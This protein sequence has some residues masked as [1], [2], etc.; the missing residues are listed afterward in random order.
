MKVRGD[1]ALAGNG[2]RLG[3]G[4]PDGLRVE[5]PLSSGRRRLPELVLGIFL[6]AGCALGAVLLAASGR[7][8]T[9]ALALSHDV[10]RGEVLSPED[11][12]T[13]Y[14]G[15]DSPI[16]FLRDGDDDQVL[17]RAALTDMK[18][19]TLV[20][21]GQFAPPTEVLGQ[22]DGAVGL[23]VEASE[24]PS[25]GL[26]PGD[27]VTVISQEPTSGAGAVAVEA[28]QVVAVEELDASAGESARWWVTLRSTEND[29]ET[30]A[31]A[32]VGDAP[33]QIILV[34]R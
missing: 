14:V 22:G 28:A 2:T 5:P 19:G 20:T 21:P 15:S 12:K 23:A 26:V 24:M 17:G 16:A 11:V 1:S 33:V 9:P 27:L 30:L 18:S 32:T 25:V 4:G 34:R 13:V 6:V 31:I 7:E 29:A 8:R 3:P 10:S